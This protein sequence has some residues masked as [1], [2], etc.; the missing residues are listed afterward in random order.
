MAK[1]GSYSGVGSKGK[2]TS[3]A[4]IKNMGDLAT[5]GKENTIDYDSHKKAVASHD[6]KVIGRNRVPNFRQN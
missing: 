3:D 2:K 6:A 1:I 4:T 5:G